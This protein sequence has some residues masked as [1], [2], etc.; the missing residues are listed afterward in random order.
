MV[1]MNRK[2]LIMDIFFF[3]SYDL[4]KLTFFL[5]N[6]FLSLSFV[7]FYLLFIFIYLLFIFIHVKGKRGIS[8]ISFIFDYI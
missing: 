7:F 2:L 4:K 8:Y 3:N 5:F 1:K 6:F